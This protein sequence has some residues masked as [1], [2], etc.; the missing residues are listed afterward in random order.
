MTDTPFIGHPVKGVF[1]L[2]FKFSAREKGFHQS[3]TLTES[4][5]TLS[6]NN[7]LRNPLPLSPAL[8]A[9]HRPPSQGHWDEDCPENILIN[10]ARA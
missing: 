4:L 1:L 6:H 3:A 10:E 9:F 7:S 2:Y 5:E 8:D